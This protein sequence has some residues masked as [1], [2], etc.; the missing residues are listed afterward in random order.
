MLCKRVLVT[1]DNDD[2]RE[3]IVRILTRAGYPVDSAVN[4]AEALRKINASP[5]PILILLDLMMPVMDGWKFLRS[6][7][8]SQ[9]KVITISAV[10]ADTMDDL[11]EGVLVDGTLQKPLFA[12]DI[13]AVVEKFCGRPMVAEPTP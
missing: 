12:K 2:T 13:L 9:H 7:G 4:G 6:R 3:M 10:H 5:E 11:G 1:E 8:S